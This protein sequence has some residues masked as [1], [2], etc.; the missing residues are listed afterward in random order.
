MYSICIQYEYLQQQLICQISVNFHIFLNFG[1]QKVESKWM[2]W[3]FTADETLELGR[4]DER[5]AHGRVGT[6]GRKQLKQQ[7]QIR[8]Q[9]NKILNFDFK[10]LHDF[11]TFF[12]R[13]FTET[14]CHF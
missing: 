4:F 3:N 13:N 2:C 6:S 9:N 12:D 8:T 14:S 11:V 10:K 5:K 7:T 1:M